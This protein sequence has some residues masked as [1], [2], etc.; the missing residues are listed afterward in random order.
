MGRWSADRGVSAWK[1]GLEGLSPAEGVLRLHVDV[2]ALSNDPEAFC[3]RMLAECC[4]AATLG[5]DLDHA[6]GRAFVRLSYWGPRLRWP[7]SLRGRG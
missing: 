6:P 5:I 1:A 4:I 3:R 2:P 7:T